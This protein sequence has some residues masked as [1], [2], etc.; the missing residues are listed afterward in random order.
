MIGIPEG[1]R[2]MATEAIVCTIC[3]AKND[4]DS[5]R[6]ASCGAKLEALGL[7]PEEQAERAG[8]QTNFRWKWVALS[9]AIFATLQAIFVVALPMAIDSYDPQ[10][11]AGLMI[12]AAIWF[13]GGIIVG[14][15]SPGRTFIEPVVGALI[16]V[17]PTI[18]WINHVS[19]VHAVSFLSMLV[20]G[21]LG[22]MVTI[23]GSFIGEK[24]QMGKK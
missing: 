1:T 3:G 4:P 12:S 22:V 18:L 14:V 24:L 13:V 11:L 7:T 5:G 20:G 21:M 17:V 23:L 2:D 19:D 6:C 10:G 15:A 9:V 16:V 8:Q